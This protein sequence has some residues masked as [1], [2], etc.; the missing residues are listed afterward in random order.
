MEYIRDIVRLQKTVDMLKAQA[1]YVDKPAEEPKPAEEAKTEA[2]AE[3]N[4]AE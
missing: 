1:K 3:A 2:P 4:K